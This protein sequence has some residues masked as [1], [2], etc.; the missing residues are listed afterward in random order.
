[1]RSKEFPN[2]FSYSLIYIDMKSLGFD[3]TMYSCEF[4]EI[5]VHGG[6]E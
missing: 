1:M 5:D 2:T 6:D 3:D 4:G